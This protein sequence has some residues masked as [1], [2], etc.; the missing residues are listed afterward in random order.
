MFRLLIDCRD[1]RLRPSPRVHIG[2]VDGHGYRPPPGHQ[3]SGE[4][5]AA[6]VP[7]HAALSDHASL[8]IA[9]REGR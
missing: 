4:V 3:L 2:E 8:I 7:D 6:R 9:V 5:R 1:Q